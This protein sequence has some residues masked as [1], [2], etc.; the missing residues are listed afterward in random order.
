[1]HAAGEVHEVTPR[2][3]RGLWLGFYGPP[4]LW[5]TQFQALYTWSRWACGTRH[6][7]VLPLLCG[8]GVALGL[9]L[10]LTSARRYR[11]YAEVGSGSSR[12]RFLA[13]LGLMGSGVFMLLIAVQGVAV[14]LITPC[15][16]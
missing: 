5:L 2:V 9:T 7:E 8:A 12:N 3:D 4:I 15:A 16:R 6:R 10:L 13:Q 14:I 11:R 1:M